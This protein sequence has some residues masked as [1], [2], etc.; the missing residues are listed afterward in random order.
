M[1]LRSSLLSLGLTFLVLVFASVSAEGQLTNCPLP[2]RWSIAVWS[3][4]D[5]VPTGEALA[6]CGDVVVEGAYWLDPQ[7]QGWLRYFP[8]HPEFGSLHTM[9]NL[10]GVIALGGMAVSPTTTPTSSPTP[11]TDCSALP[12]DLQY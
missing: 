8:A 4:T 2:G 7:T 6:T 9:D 10:Q 5:D 11:E 1:L 3:G 12:N